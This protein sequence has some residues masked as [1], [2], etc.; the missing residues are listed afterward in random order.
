MFSHKYL[1]S[2]LHNK[3]LVYDMRGQLC[4]VSY[5]TLSAS[6][7]LMFGLLNFLLLD[8]NTFAHLF[9]SFVT[10]CQFCNPIFSI[11]TE[12]VVFHSLTLLTKDILVSFRLVLINLKY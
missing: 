10:Q 5:V 3:D 1:F 4:S 11:V 12:G 9:F 2:F 8:N 6:G 7:N